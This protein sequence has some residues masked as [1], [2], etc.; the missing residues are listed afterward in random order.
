[1]PVQNMSSAIRRMGVNRY[2]LQYTCI[3]SNAPI[4]IPKILRRI[5]NPKALV[6]ALYGSQLNL[7]IPLICF[8]EF[9]D[10]DL[11]NLG[12]IRKY[13]KHGSERYSCTAC[14]RFFRFQ[15]SASRHFKTCKMASAMRAKQEDLDLQKNVMLLE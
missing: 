1:M 9:E 6:L 5:N 11:N 13:I 2:R 7:A 15:N 4:L 14:N 8:S 3:E 10:L 12:K